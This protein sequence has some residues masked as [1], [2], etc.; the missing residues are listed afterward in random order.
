MKTKMKTKRFTVV[1]AVA[2]ALA[3]RPAAWGDEIDPGWPRR[4]LPLPPRPPRESPAIS[5]E[6]VYLEAMATVDVSTTG[7]LEDGTLT[8]EARLRLD[9]PGKYLYAL[10]KEGE[11]RGIG[12]CEGVYRNFG[13]RTFTVQLPCTELPARYILTGYFIPWRCVMTSFG[14]K[15]IE[16]PDGGPLSGDRQDLSRLIIVEEVSGDV[17]V[18]VEE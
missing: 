13:S 3:C 2:L 15:L 18:C 10:R 12:P 6:D 9:G 14:P 7:K 8:V 11:D 16:D 4:P 17:R 1:L 5:S